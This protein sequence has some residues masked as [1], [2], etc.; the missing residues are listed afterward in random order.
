MNPQIFAEQVEREVRPRLFDSAM[1]LQHRMGGPNILVVDD[2]LVIR[3][4]LST[5]L[6][7]LGCSVRTAADGLIALSAITA[8]IPD[9]LISDLNMPRMCGFELLSLVRRRFPSIRV[10]AMSGG[11]SGQI[12]PSGVAAD[13]FYEKGGRCGTSLLQLVSSMLEPIKAERRSPG[14]TMWIP[15]QS[16]S[17]QIEHSIVISCPEC[18]RL[19]SHGPLETCGEMTHANCPHCC[20]P[21][22]FAVCDC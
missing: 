3:Q 9:I 5:V 17:F 21:L 8:E 11:Y 7:E 13:A 20:N 2:E 10:I 14:S 4:T 6:A 18:L 1:P 15:I 19:F 22:V 16:Q 12:V